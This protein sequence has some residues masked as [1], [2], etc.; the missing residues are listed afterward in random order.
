M[1]WVRRPS[2]QTSTT[3]R[4]ANQENE[5]KKTLIAGIIGL[6]LLA[7]TYLE[8]ADQLTLFVSQRGSKLRIEGTA[9]TGDWQAETPFIAGSLEAGPDFPKEPGQEVKPGKV[10]A[11]VDLFITVRALK[12]VNKDRTP[13][14]DGMDTKMW[15]MLKAEDHPKITY[16]SIEL[17]LKEAPK[18]KDA[19]YVFDS[20]G[21]LVVAGVT[22]KISMPV[23]V[24]PLPDKK[25]KITGT[26]PLKMT[27]FGIEPAKLILVVKTSD[28]IKISFEWFVVEKAPAAAAPK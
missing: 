5:M 26:K 10:D 21:E 22:N 14:S 24:L 2:V 18:T 25:L 1:N 11:K 27:D 13:Y 7:G 8:A 4:S 19:P 6:L 28:D 16:R 20:T 17:V 3:E 15:S 12:S 9:T 23:S